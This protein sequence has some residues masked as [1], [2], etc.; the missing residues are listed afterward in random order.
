MPKT[1]C[2]NDKQEEDKMTRAKLLHQRKIEFAPH[3]S[4]DLTGDGAVGAREYFIA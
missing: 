4:F 1:W 2:P 3:P